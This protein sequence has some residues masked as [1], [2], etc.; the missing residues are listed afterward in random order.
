MGSILDNII[1]KKAKGRKSFAVLLDPDNINAEAC[2]KIV[3]LA[4]ENKVDY[5]FV[6]GSLL[7]DD[8]IETVI[9]IIKKYSSIP[10]LLF[11]GNLHH[12]N[13]NAD[14]ILLLSL[15]SGRNPDFL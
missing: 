7:T 15:I 13:N 11:P 3:T 9:K 2:K 5:F 10:V 4:N 8:N 12:I 1:K 6:G 14:S